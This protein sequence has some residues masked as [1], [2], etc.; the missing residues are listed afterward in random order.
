MEGENN[1]FNVGELDNIMDQQNMNNAE[2]HQIKKKQKTEKQNDFFDS[3]NM[4]L[5]NQIDT[6][7]NK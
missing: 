2:R 5:K 3:L 6:R 4:D 7:E 1:E